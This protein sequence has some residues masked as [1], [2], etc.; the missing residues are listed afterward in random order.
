MF[1]VLILIIMWSRILSLYFCISGYVD[2]ST[3]RPA[4]Q[5]S[6]TNNHVTC[7]RVQPQLRPSAEAVTAPPAEDAPA[8]EAGVV[9]ET[10]ATPEETSAE[11]VDQQEEA[12]EASAQEGEESAGEEI[13]KDDA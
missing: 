2:I 12:P 11:A 1:N 9:E 3:V 5:L 4:A 8:E 6:P 7:F 13:K 10:T